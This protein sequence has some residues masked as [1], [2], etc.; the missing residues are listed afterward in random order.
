MNAIKTTNQFNGTC[1]LLN[2]LY[3]NYSADHETA[4][5][6]DCNTSLLYK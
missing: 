6:V 5:L 4:C 3:S 2:T 1:S